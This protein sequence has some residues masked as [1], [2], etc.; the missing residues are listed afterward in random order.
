MKKEPNIKS[1][2]SSQY[3]VRLESNQKN[4]ANL[5]II[6]LLL[7]NIIFIYLITYIFFYLEH[8]KEIIQIFNSFEYIDYFIFLLIVIALRII[9]SLSLSF[10]FIKKWL[11]KDIKNYFDIPLL[12]GLFFYINSVIK[13]LDITIFIMYIGNGLFSNSLILNIYKIRQIIGAFSTLALLSIGTYLFLF[14][15]YFREKNLNKDEVIEK[16]VK[17]VLVIWLG[18]YLTVII[19]SPNVLLLLVVYLIFSSVLC[20]IIWV[21]ISAH[22]GKILPEINCLLISLGFIS[23]LIFHFLPQILIYLFLTT[24]IQGLLI[25]TLIGEAGILFSFILILIGFKTKASYYK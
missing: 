4:K 12:F 9:I 15:R 14:K 23:Y 17:V 22:K 20:P 11:N 18:A 7:S 21:F 13:F 10:F 1:S 24:T 8:T 16:K 19:F 6:G 3:R 2:Q 5:L 25:A